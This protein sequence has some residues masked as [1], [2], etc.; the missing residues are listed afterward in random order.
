MT[1]SVM[2]QS[3]DD[4]SDA[5]RSCLRRLLCEFKDRETEES[6]RHE[7]LPKQKKLVFKLA[8]FVTLA[9]PMFMLSDSLIVKPEPWQSFLVAQRLAQILICLIFLF[10]VHKISTLRQYDVL[11]S[12]TLLLFFTLLQI[13]SFTFLDDYLLY[14]LFDLIIII[15]IYAAGLLTIRLSMLLC[16]YHALIATGIILFLKDTTVHSQIMLI[17]AYTF[18]NGAG[19]LLATF[20]HRAVRF[21]YYLKT[22]L[23]EKSLQLKQ[24][25]YRDSLT[26]ALNRRAFQEHFPDL[27]KMI[28]RMDKEDGELFLVAADIDHFKSIN[29]TYGHDIG[30]KVLVAFVAMIESQIRPQDNVYRFGGEEFMLLFMGCPK[31]T[32]INRIE[33]IMAILNA[34][35]LNVEEL[36]KPVTCSF[37]ISNV[38][39]TDSVDSVCIRAD[40]ALYEAKNSGRNRYVFKRA[41]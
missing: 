12:C 40:E 34:S 7:I 4:Q 22:S 38:L 28:E 5:E 16:L 18:S 30:D 19:L 1:S 13:G 23:R 27:K 3:P 25:A 20:Y 9:M 2:Q 37:G 33:Q 32:L 17:L 35:G 36:S 26:N 6:F 21:E 24:L 8:A 15:S 39:A 10:L 29:D 41:E 14:A 31:Q 11:V